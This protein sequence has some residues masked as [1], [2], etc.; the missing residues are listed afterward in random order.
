MTAADRAAGVLQGGANA[1]QG[2]AHEARSG[3]RDQ[4]LSDR[5]AAAHARWQAGLPARN[6]F[7]RDAY[8]KAEVQVT[9]GRMYL[10]RVAER[11]SAVEAAREAEAGS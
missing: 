1:V 4:G 5:E 10:D 11:A 7:E 2:T 8:A 9:G 3:D 6:Q